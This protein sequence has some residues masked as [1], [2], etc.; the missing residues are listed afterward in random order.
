MLRTAGA[1]VLVLALAAGPAHAQT[2]GGGGGLWDL[3]RLLQDTYNSVR[4]WVT[5]QFNGAVDA[6]RGN[7]APITDAYHAANSI[8]RWLESTASGLPSGFRWI[9]DGAVARFR[10]APSPPP[11]SISHTVQQVI[12]D[13][14]DSPIA[15]KVHA[16]EELSAATELSVARSR[17]AQKSAEDTAQQ[18]SQ[19]LSMAA[20]LGVAESTARELAARAAQTPS[21][22]AAVQLL[23]EG[24]AAFMDQQ[25]R[26][27]ADVSA[28]IT[29]MVQ[30]QAALSQQL[31][32]VT[33]KVSD[34]VELMSEQQKREA[35]ESLVAARSAVS[36][37]LGLATGGLA[38]IASMAPG[39]QSRERE[40]RMYR[41]ISEV[42]RR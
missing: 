25:A 34:L 11:G 15:R 9:L 30:Q 29:A 21:T 5:S 24:F 26:Q 4:N 27:N 2:A 1:L 16:H 3:L 32:S 7:L 13:N 23:I 10:Q 35:E 20:N 17:A 36:S 14:P 8:A 42:Y 40:D 12:R 6:I 31:T 38:A 39:D 28:R 22:R 18:V 41:S 33:E 19:D 37:G